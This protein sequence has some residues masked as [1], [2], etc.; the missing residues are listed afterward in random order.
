VVISNPDVFVKPDTM[1]KMLSYMEEHPEIGLLGP[2]LRYYNGDTQESCRRHMTF[3]DLIIKR[4]PLQR[5]PLFKKRLQKYLMHDFDHS[6]IQEVDL[7]TGAYFMMKREVYDE[8]GG[9][10]PRYFLFMEDFDL[11]RKIHAAGYKVV[12]FAKAEAEHY[13][14]RLSGGNMLWLLSRKIFWIHLS[15]AIKY[16]WK[17]RGKSLKNS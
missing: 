16:F 7:I 6:Q 14:K 15:S 3:F 1:K 10:D 13:H 9:F 2:R 11:C 8:V 12:Y 17:W 5:I 4:T